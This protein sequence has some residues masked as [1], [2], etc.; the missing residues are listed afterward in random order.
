MI[1][2]KA[3][4]RWSIAGRLTAWYAAT[5]FVLVTGAVGLQ[6]RTVLRDLAEED[7]QLLLETSAAVQQDVAVRLTRIHTEVSEGDATSHARGFDTSALAG[8]GVLPTAPD[9]P[10]LRLLDEQCK[11]LG[12]RAR[13]PLPPP[14]CDANVNDSLGLRSWYSPNGAEWRIA[15]IRL[16]PHGARLEV[17]L[18]RASDVAVLGRLRHQLY[19]LLPLALL[20]SIALGLLIAQ[21]G[22]APIA[23]LAHRVARVDARSLDQDLRLDHAPSEVRALGGSFDEMLRRLRVAFNALSEYSGEMAHELRTPLHVL[24]QQMEVVLS[25]QRSPEEYREVLGSNL[26]EVERLRRMIDDMLFLARAEDPR[27]AVSRDTIEPA[28]ELRSVCDFMDA[29]AE[30]GNVQLECDAPSNLVMTGDR[31]L[32]RRALVNLVANAL[33]HTPEGGSIRLSARETDAGVVLA[34]QDT[35]AGIP[36]GELAHIFDRYFRVHSD[37]GTNGSGAGLGL[38]IVQGIA[39]LHGGSVR[40][41]STEGHGTRIEILFSQPQPASSDEEE[42]RRS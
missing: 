38:A 2:G 4:R 21:R 9:G 3:G 31:T 28:V 36:T 27:S 39:H 42:K 10:S 37:L 35:G 11:T 19:V 12:S 8:W 40:A 7:D 30:A 22:L 34:V 23:L 24:R 32:V 14:D 26:E 41:E 6:Y 15:T 33:A 29:L 17:L 1:I 13:S 18:D 16:T 25:R 5:A 20:I